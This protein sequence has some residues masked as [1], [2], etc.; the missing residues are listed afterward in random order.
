MPRGAPA[1]GRYVNPTTGAPGL[2]VRCV[3]SAGMGRSPLTNHTNTH[4]AQLPLPVTSHINK[5]TPKSKHNQR[6]HNTP[7]SPHRYVLLARFALLLPRGA[8]RRAVDF[9]GTFASNFDFVH[10]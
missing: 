8:R 3:R 9:V 5:F 10:L 2:H 6:E 7:A 4:E 1:E